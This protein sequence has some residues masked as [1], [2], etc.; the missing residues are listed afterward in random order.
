MPVLLELQRAFGAALLDGARPQAL[1]ELAR[2]L[3]VEPALLAIHRH[4]GLGTLCG[5]LALSFPAVRQLVGAD[6]FEAAAREFIAA[7]APTQACLNDYG[8]QFPQFL[9]QFPPAAALSYLADVARLEWAVARAL[10]APDAPDAAPLAL[11]TLAALDA[12]LM[13]RVRFAAHPALAVLA[14]ASPADA[15]WRA[16]LAQDEAAMAAL[17]PTAGPVWLLIERGADGVQ[18]RRLSALG[19]AFTG[20]LC[21]GESL[22]RALEG[23]AGDGLID[24]PLDALLAEHLASGRFTSWSVDA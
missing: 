22:E 4:T 17:D 10:H 23:A 18:V 19:G 14:L 7:Q 1:S 3:E 24:E 6:F 2:E 11:S 8:Q 9:A 20:R 5:A 15:I 16:V 13:P 21:A 12:A